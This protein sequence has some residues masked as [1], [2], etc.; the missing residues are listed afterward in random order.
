MKAEKLGGSK[1]ARSL[2]NLSSWSQNVK[3]ISIIYM[4]YRRTV[5]IK[6]S[7]RITDKATLKAYQ[8][9][10]ITETI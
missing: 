2:S 10:S 3:I 4:K 1:K 8:N 9:W 5:V 6:L 7:H